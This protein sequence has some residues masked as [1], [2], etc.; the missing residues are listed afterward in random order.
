METTSPALSEPFAATLKAGRESFNARFAE[1]RRGGSSID[2][3]AFLEHLANVVDPIVDAIARHFSERTRAAV[4]ELYDLSLELFSASL[5]G[6]RARMPE[7]GDVWQRLLPSVARLLARD[8]ARV[9]G[10]LSNA[11]WNLAQQPETRTD[12]WIDA[13]RDLAPECESIDD[14]LDCGKIVAWQAGMAQYRAGALETAR[15][16]APVLAARAL[17]L[18]GDASAARVAAAVDRLER[19]PWL[20]T[21][22]AVETDREAK[23][24]ARV[25]ALGAFRGFGGAFLRPPTVS[26]GDDFLCVGDG[27]FFWQLR[28]DV[29]GWHLHRCGSA[30]APAKKSPEQITI[31]PRGT[32]T[33]QQASA[34]FPDLAGA[35]SLGCDGTTAAVTVPTSH[36]IL[37]LARR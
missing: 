37:L 3:A 1:R 25:R 31:D 18:P 22:S 23:S 30:S 7:V 12:W 16:L 8:P 5:L 17:R 20:T 14:L 19:D 6:P 29:Y 26:E 36:Q 35:S 27:E 2:A 32:V 33:W 9:A 34:T 24:I 21:E 10:A 28:A 15:K 11:A 4:D 13:L